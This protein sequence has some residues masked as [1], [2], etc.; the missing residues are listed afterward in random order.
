MI[1]KRHIFDELKE[2]F[3]LIDKGHFSK[4][5]QKKNLDHIIDNLAYY[6]PFF[7]MADLPDYLACSRKCK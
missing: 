2:V 3:N 4:V 1:H 7:V 6:D 5:E